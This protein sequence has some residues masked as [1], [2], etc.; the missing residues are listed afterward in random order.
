MTEQQTAVGIFV[1]VLVIVVVAV[2]LGAAG[3]FAT[4]KSWTG[5]S[6]TEPPAIIGT[7]RNLEACRVDVGKVGGWCG[8][9]CRNYGAGQFAD[10]A[11]LTKVEKV[12]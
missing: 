2:V 7:Y 1:I 11:P 4:H 9:E 10:C 12:K 3:I 8:K 5:L 6:A